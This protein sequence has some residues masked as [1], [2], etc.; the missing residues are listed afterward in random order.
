MIAVF[1]PHCTNFSHEKVNSG[2]IYGLRLA[3]PDEKIRFYADPT[4]LAAIRK[5]LDHDGISIGNIEYVPAEFLNPYTIAGYFK[6]CSHFKKVFRDVL[7]N[8]SDKIF[9][10]TYMPPHLHLI[11]KLKKKAQFSKLKFTFVLHGSFE[12]IAGPAAGPD[13][14]LLPL[15]VKKVEHVDKP[16]HQKTWAEKSRREKLTTTNPID[17]LR[18]IGSALKRRFSF[19]I[20]EK[21]LQ[22]NLTEE[23]VLLNEPG[24]DYHYIALSPHI[25]PHAARFMDISKLKIYP[26]I[27]PTFF[28]N[29]VPRAENANVKFAA[30]G[31]SGTSLP[32]YNLAYKLNQ[33]N[34]KQP[35][36]IRII[37]GMDDRSAEAEWF[38]SVKR[39]S[40]GK[41]ISR[42][43]MEEQ[44]KDVDFFL[45]LYD[46][47]RYRLSCSSSMLEALSNMKP[48]LH[49][50]NDCI[51]LFNDPK[52]PMGIRCENLDQMADEMAKIIEN[53]SSYREKLE[54]YRNNILAL[55]SKFSIE[56]SKEA[57]RNSF[58]W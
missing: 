22:K 29:S 37:G 5:I 24:D 6:T 42:D 25:L 11:K 46:R 30:F 27:L 53:F 31:G 14:S 56:S 54:I 38:P 39:P 36:E 35:Y 32:L 26:V 28:R 13:P 7:Q 9:V 12:R 58:T 34:P 2:F 18:G 57:I 44:A 41:A 55:R 21:Y 51:D 45:V 16:V 3:F 10:L 52:I 4:H 19:G 8:G 33:K 1:D 23:K 17:F 15:P 49:L 48:V 47:N 43:E 50:A 20:W 40:K